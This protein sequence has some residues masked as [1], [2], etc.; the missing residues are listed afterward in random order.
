V[1]WVPTCTGTTCDRFATVTRLSDGKLL[2]RSASTYC[3]IDAVNG[4]PRRLDQRLRAAIGG[5]AV[6]RRE[7][8]A[9]A[10]PAAP[11]VVRPGA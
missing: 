9:R 4:R 2:A 1:T 5:P 11:A 10:F 8:E 7:R 6:V 3:A